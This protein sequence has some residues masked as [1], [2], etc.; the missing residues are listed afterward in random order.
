MIPG[1]TTRLSEAVLSL[2]TTVKF[3]ADLIRITST[4]STTVASTVIPAFAGQ[5][6]MT[7]V[8]NQSGA[9]ITTVTTGNIGTAVTIADAAAVVFVFSADTNKWIVGA[10]L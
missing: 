1:I 5:A 8:V 4:S 7:I 3:N 6:G 10:L 9:S 2:E